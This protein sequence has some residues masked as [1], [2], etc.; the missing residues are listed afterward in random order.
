MPVLCPNIDDLRVLRAYS[1]LLLLVR[2]L[3]LVFQFGTII[4]ALVII[5]VVRCA[6]RVLR[7]LP[8]VAV[9][10]IAASRAVTVE[11]LYIQ[12]LLPSTS[13]LLPW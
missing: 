12:W 1:A 13:R 4:Q 6:R 11:A 10:A 3:V 5:T 7:A 9:A 2:R 8:I